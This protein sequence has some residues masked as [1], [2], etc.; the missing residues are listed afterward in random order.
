MDF[1]RGL[2]ATVDWY[3]NNRDWVRRVKSGEY[4]SYYSRNYEN[5]TLELDRIAT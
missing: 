5:R 2:T 3:R 4:Q 1:E